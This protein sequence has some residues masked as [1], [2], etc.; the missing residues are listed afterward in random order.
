MFCPNHVIKP[1]KS[2][3][4]RISFAAGPKLTEIKEYQKNPEEW[5]SQPMTITKKAAAATSPAE[6]T[7]AFAEPAAEPV[8]D[9][10]FDEYNDCDI[11]LTQLSSLASTNAVPTQCIVAWSTSRCSLCSA[12][13]RTFGFAVS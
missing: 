4:R 3:G 10:T 11:N 8:G 7:T 5:A 9:V 2:T 13:Y 12:D 6:P 1:R